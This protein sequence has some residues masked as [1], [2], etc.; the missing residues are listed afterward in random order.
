MSTVVYPNEKFKMIWIRVLTRTHVYCM[1]NTLLT[2]FCNWWTLR[3]VTRPAH[4]WRSRGK[5]AVLVIR[6]VVARFAPTCA[7]LGVKCY[8]GADRTLRVLQPQPG[9]WIRIHF[10]RIWIQQFF[11]LCGSGSRC[12][13]DADPVPAQTN[14]KKITI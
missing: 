4:P 9:L 8:S 5:V 12:L 1:Y 6:M 7:M 3:G 2:T 14:L 10:L 13:K 11:F